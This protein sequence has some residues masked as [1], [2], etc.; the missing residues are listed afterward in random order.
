MTVEIE[1]GGVI[2]LRGLFR[3]D[4]DQL[5]M[6]QCMMA[7]Q[8]VYQGKIDGK[9]ACVWGLVPP[10]IMS[11]KAYIW[12]WTTSVADEH[13]FI[14]VRNSQHMVQRML[15]EYDSLIGHCRIGDD[16]AIRW[17]KWLRA[18]FGEPQGM[19]VPFVIRRRNG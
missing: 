1:C 17:M 11:D 9:V 2:D 14:L 7:S 3:S 18:E 15:E 19:L 12:L 8:V 5:T 4:F 13:T 6:E 16:R 10:T